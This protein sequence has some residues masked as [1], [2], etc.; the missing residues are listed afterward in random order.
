MLYDFTLWGAIVKQ[1]NSQIHRDGNSQIHR[2]GRMA[3]ARAWVEGGMEDI[4]QREEFHFG[5]TK[6]FRRQM[7]MT[8]APQREY[9]ICPTPQD[10]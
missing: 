9:N 3:V 6:A 1:S 8:V 5:M 7:V 2:D 10:G 4:Y